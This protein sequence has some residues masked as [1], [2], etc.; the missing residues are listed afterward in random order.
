[1]SKKIE[2][3]MI[4]VA[5]VHGEHSMPTIDLLETGFVRAGSDYLGTV[6]SI[7]LTGKY[8]IGQIYRVYNGEEFLY[9]AQALSV[10]KLDGQ[11]ATLFVSPEDVDLAYMC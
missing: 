10:D 6:W 8:R 7:S 9:H 3:A 1:M 2:P 4:P 5:P 11:D